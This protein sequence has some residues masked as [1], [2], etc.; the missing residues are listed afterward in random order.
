MVPKGRLRERFA[1]GEW[2]SLL[3]E[4]QEHASRGSQ[5]SR[6]HRRREHD[7]DVVRRAGRAEACVQ[8]G[9]LSSARQCLEGAPVAPGNR[10]TL[11]AL[12]DPS[13]RPAEPRD[14]IPADVLE[15]QP[16]SLLNL[17]VEGFSRNIRC[18]KR[19]VA[20]GPSG[21]TADHLRPIL[22]SEAD[23]AALGRMATDLARADIPLPI[24]TALRMGRLTALQKPTGGVRGIV[25][26][27]VF[28]RLVPQHR[29]TVGLRSGGRN[30]TI[31]VRFIN[32]SRW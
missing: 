15:F 11:L 27:E 6:R 1:R 9:E 13:K 31:S 3:T 23:T 18:A 7:D 17:D 21:M 16:R 8:A 14:P 4:S 30:V 26:G 2:E 19:G 20:G 12:R 28:R 32:E 22:E 10:N 25:T 5:A 29:P 24:L